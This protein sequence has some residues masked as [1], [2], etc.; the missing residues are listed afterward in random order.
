MSSWMS[1]YLYIRKVSGPD[2]LNIE[3]KTYSYQGS[4]QNITGFY[5]NEDI[6][7]VVP[8]LGEFN[9]SREISLSKHPIF[10]RGLGDDLHCVG[11]TFFHLVTALCFWWDFL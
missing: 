6:Q 10:E 2:W 5:I 8:I 4:S 3:I 1:P 11:S 7:R 9:M